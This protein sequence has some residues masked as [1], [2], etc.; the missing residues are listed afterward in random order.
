[1]DKFAP[2][3]WS[4]R[5]SV[6]LYHTISPETPDFAKGAFPVKTPEQFEKDLDL[7]LKKW[8]PA[9]VDD[10]FSGESG[11]GKF[12][13]TFDDG[14]RGCYDYAMPIL[15][16]KGIQ[17]VFFVNPS[18]VDNQG[19]FYR[20]KANILA[21]YIKLKASE[22]APKTVIKNKHTNFQ[23]KKEE[24]LKVLRI[25]GIITKDPLE[26]LKRATYHHQT[27]LDEIASTLQID[28]CKYLEVNQPYMSM[29]NLE[30]LNRNGF[31]IGAHS[32]RHPLYSDV[33]PQKQFS[34][35]LE[36]LQW[37]RQNFNPSR[38][39]FAFPFTADGVDAGLIEKVNA[40]IPV[41]A[42]F[43]TSGYH[44][45]GDVVQRIALDSDQVPADKLLPFEI[46]Y[47]GV[48]KLIGV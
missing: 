33:L 17:A 12:L 4:D 43:G 42:F 2:K 45:K 29:A 35:T 36:S 23:E 31:V 27:L 14:L 20:Y 46:I 24:T 9:E 34:E 11:Q 30:E 10:L 28:F 39:L 8:K 6:L 3:N 40:K 32:M 44:Y 26:W 37:I 19:L 22:G 25:H 1:M 15:L 13:I 47:S 16:R 21:E 18:F 7:L 48:K 38:L 5:V 41:D